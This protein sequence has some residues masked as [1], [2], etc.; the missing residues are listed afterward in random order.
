[1]K[2]SNPELAPT[3]IVPDQTAQSEELTLPPY[4]MGK[5]LFVWSVH[6]VALVSVVL[7]LMGLIT[8]SINTAVLAVV[9]FVLSSTAIT[10]GYHRLYSHLAYSASPI[11]DVFYLF[12]GAVTVQGSALQWAAQHRDHHTFE[13]GPKD[14][15][16][17]ELG[18]WY[19]HMGWVVRQTTPDYER[20]K[21]LKK[22]TLIRLQHRFFGPLAMFGSF[23]VPMLLGAL[24]GE[25]L[26]ALLVAG[27]VRLTVQWHMTFCVNSVAHY[28]GSQ[29]Y[30]TK[31]SARG[32]WWL[33]F[34]V[35]G[36]MD[37]NYHHT[38]PND[39]RT[40]TRWYDF[41]PG[42]WW[43][44]AASKL[45]LASDLR[46]VPDSRIETALDRTKSR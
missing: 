8:V 11:L 15:Y 25:A 33:S 9:W 42:K 40:G 23:G 22:S 7:A 19:A 38:F 14:P 46:S 27:F 16:N 6:A 31:S 18:F 5:F 28:F 3:E 1:M 45:G 41:D 24:W 35:W 26:S 39:F 13:D 36:E 43:I 29:K 4:D 10:A 12:F 21:D 37:H 17:I 30:S 34:F 2:T 32:T 20:V 44:F